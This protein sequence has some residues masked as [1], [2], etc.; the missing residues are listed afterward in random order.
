MGDMK[1]L[2]RVSGTLDLSQFWPNGHSDV[3][4]ATV[5]V[6]AGGFQFSKDGS[7]QGL[8]RTD[9]FEHAYIGQTAVIGKGRKVQVRI[10]GID[11]PELHCPPGARHPKAPKA[12]GAPP[13][14]KKK[15]PPLKGNGG[16][17]RQFQGRTS[18]ADLAAT[19]G[20]AKVGCTITTR[21]D[22]PNDVFD[23][24]GRLIGDISFRLKDK[25]VNI[26]HLAAEHGWA[27][28]AYYNSMNRSEINALQ[29]L[30]E[31]AR[32][33]KRGIWREFE[34]KVGKLE[35][36]EFDKRDRK[37]G[38]A[39]RRADKK[40]FVVPK[41]YRRQLKFDVMEL[42]NLG[43]ATIRD[44][45]AGK[46]SKGQTRGSKDPWT[47][48]A[49]ILKNPMMKRPTKAPN[50]S[51]AGALSA[52][53]TFPTA[54]GVAQ[55]GDIVFFEDSTSLRK[56]KKKKDKGTVIKPDDWFA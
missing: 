47:T 33:K 55:P 32:K 40:G 48:R 44:F 7:P 9:V 5:V 54:V 34:K 13:K 24:H 17:F 36:L 38:A 42:N 31:D 41:M 20:K 11:A 26:S 15:L 23:S 25:L 4:T 12:N 45:L 35:R 56:K 28:P 6:D 10:Q 16:F 30:F 39:E 19:V 8:R 2:L 1:G 49:A 3:D 22:E 18:T 14:P 53:N 52:Q 37:F 21:V 51:L 29:D 50:D 43:P 46:P 27:L